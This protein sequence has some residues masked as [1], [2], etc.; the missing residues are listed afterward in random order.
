MK[1]KAVLTNAEH[2][3]RTTREIIRRATRLFGTRGYHETSLADILAETG[4]TKGALYHHF[5]D[6]R[7]LFRQV[8]ISARQEMLQIAGPENPD[9]LNALDKLFRDF[10]KLAE[11]VVEKKFLQIIVVD[12]PTVFTS[13]EWAQLNE[14]YFLEPTRQYLREL[15]KQNR[16]KDGSIDL[17]SLVLVGSVNEAMRT[18]WVSGRASRVHEIVDVVRLIL[19]PFLR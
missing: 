19:S 7:D 17:L 16:L 5:K 11:F 12:A 8:F 15:A 4:L 1:R 18:Y 3:E 9:N 14:K 10:K 6:K 2:T 13:K